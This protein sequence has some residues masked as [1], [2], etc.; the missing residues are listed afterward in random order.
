MGDPPVSEILG[1][2]K[3][4]AIQKMKLSMEGN[5]FRYLP[6]RGRQ[7]TND[8]LHYRRQL[9]DGKLIFVAHAD[10]YV[11]LCSC[12]KVA[13]IDPRILHLGVM[14][15]E[16]RLD[17]IEKQFPDNSHNPVDDKL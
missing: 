2:D 12:A 9:A 14:K 10:Y 1:D 6:P 17:S 8:Y 5:G 16:R 4:D 11:L 13:R 7:K 15:L 3:G